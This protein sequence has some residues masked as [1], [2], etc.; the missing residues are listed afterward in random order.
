MTKVIRVLLMAVLVFVTIAVF[1][2]MSCEACAEGST[3]MYCTGNNVNER[4]ANNTKSV[5][6]RKHEK[7]ERVHVIA[8]ENGWFQLTNGHWMSSEYLHTADEVGEWF[9]AN[10][11][12][13]MYVRA[14]NLNIRAEPSTKS[15][16]MGELKA[17]TRVKVLSIEKRWALLDNGFYVND[18]YLKFTPEELMEYYMNKYDDIIFISIS[19]QYSYYY[20]GGEIIGAADVVTGKDTT[21]TPIGLYT[22]RYRDIDCYLME[23]SFVHYFTAFVGG[24]GI[25]D[26][27]WRTSFGGTRYHKHGSHGCVNTTYSF[28]ELVYSKSREGKTKVLVIS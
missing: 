25:H 10:S 2:W 22:V 17:G 20:Y 7:G 23:D 11:F 13:Y 4:K 21:P 26:A 16:K 28:A 12:E 5:V 9:V 19:N 24:I 3:V 15:N 18:S 27:S 6:V 8:E 14:E 1:Q